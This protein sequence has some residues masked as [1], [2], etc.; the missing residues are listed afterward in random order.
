MFPIAIRYL[1]ILAEITPKNLLVG[2]TTVHQVRQKSYEYGNRVN[3][4]PD[5]P[6]HLLIATRTVNDLLWRIV[7]ISNWSFCELANFGSDW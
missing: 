6:I 7:N 1:Y 3:H 5:S 2:F 4:C